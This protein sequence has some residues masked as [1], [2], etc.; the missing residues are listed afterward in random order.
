VIGTAVTASESQPDG[1]TLV[2]NT[3]EV[4]LRV[5]RGFD[6]KMTDVLAASAVVRSVHPHE[7]GEQAVR[8]ACA[9][10]VAD[11][12]VASVITVLGTQAPDTLILT[13]KGHANRSRLYSVLRTLKS[14][15]FVGA[16][17][18]VFCSDALAR[19]RVAYDGPM[20]DLVD[21]LTPGVYEGRPLEVEQVIQRNMI[22]F[23]P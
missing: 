18:E 6:G 21:L 22:L 12:L 16:V 14:S 3:A 17:E 5:F 11:T 2:R 23:F 13:V 1:S 8:D 7:G 9:K 20:L 15:P 10:L 4:T 19:Y